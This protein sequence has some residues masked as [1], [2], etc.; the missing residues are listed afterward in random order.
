MI[1]SKGSNTKNKPE[2]ESGRAQTHAVYRIWIIHAFVSKKSRLT[3]NRIPD[4]V[5]INLKE[6]ASV[7]ASWSRFREVLHLSA[8]MNHGN[9]DT[10]TASPTTATLKL[11]SLFL[12]DL[13]LI[14][15][16]LHQN[17]H[18]SAFPFVGWLSV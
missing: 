6:A 5:I 10:T 4:L 9:L 7:M 3:R 13:G 11:S 2:H 18:S 15:H 14:T 17:L 8:N 12:V 1:S 16:S